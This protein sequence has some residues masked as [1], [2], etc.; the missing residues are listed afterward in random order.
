MPIRPRRG[1]T[2]QTP[3]PVIDAM[4]SYYTDHRASI[5]RGVYPLA[6]EATDLFEGARHFDEDP[7]DQSAEIMPGEGASWALGFVADG[8]LLHHT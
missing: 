8:E 4:T 3:Q 6:V 5:H 7:N 2:S 1:R